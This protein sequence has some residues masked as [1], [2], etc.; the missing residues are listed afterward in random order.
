MT[1][2]EIIHCASLQ[3]TKQTRQHGC[4]ATNHAGHRCPIPS[5]YCRHIVSSWFEVPVV[6]LERLEWF[7]AGPY[8]F[9]VL[10]IVVHPCCTVCTH[11]TSR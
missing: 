4:R 7:C 1:M 5:V 3:S 10:V 9:L 6:P 8:S 11:N 2:A